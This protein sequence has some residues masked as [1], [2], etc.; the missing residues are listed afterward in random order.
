MTAEQRCRQASPSRHDLRDPRARGR[1]TLRRLCLSRTRGLTALAL[2]PGSDLRLP[3]DVTVAYIE[4][5]CSFDEVVDFENDGNRPDQETLNVMRAFNEPKVDA[6]V[7]EFKKA[8][9]ADS[10]LFDLH[11]GL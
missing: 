3:V 2:L 8:L 7:D 11:E 9:R 6:A 5:G 10:E 1:A 4:A